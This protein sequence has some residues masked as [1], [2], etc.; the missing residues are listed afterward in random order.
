MNPDYQ[1]DLVWSLEDKVNLIDSIYNDIE[2]GRFAFIK[3]D[4][5]KNNFDFDKDFYWEILDGKQRI[6]AIIDFFEEF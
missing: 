3:T 2:I 4:Y 5:S 1:R 6:S